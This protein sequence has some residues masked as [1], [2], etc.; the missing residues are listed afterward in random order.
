M[1]LKLLLVGKHTS[2]ELVVLRSL[3]CLPVRVVFVSTDCPNQFPSYPC[4]VRSEFISD[5][6]LLS[7]AGKERLLQIAKEESVAAV[8]V[9]WRE[10][11]TYW[12]Q[13][14]KNAFVVLSSPANTL[15]ELASKK[16]QLYYAARCGFGVLPTYFVSKQKVPDIPAVAFPIVLRPDGDTGQGVT[17]LFK[18]KVIMSQGE[19]D[20]AMKA[21][22]AHEKELIAQPFSRLSHLVLHGWRRTDGHLVLHAFVASRKFAGLVLCLERLADDTNE[23]LPARRFLEEVGV[24]GAFHFDLLWDVSTATPYFLEINARLGGTT[25]KV[26]ALGYNEPAAL[27]ASFYPAFADQATMRPTTVKVVATKTTILRY[28]LAALK[29]KTDLCDYPAEPHYKRVLWGMSA[30]F[31]TKD[32]AWSGTDWRGWFALK[33]ARRLTKKSK[34]Q[35]PQ[36]HLQHSNREQ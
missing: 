30:L 22:Q 16:R 3:S 21:I 13:E 19:L 35:Q 6:E 20:A 29:N 11:L 14:K 32:E 12:L 27:L 17:P 7:A 34:C 24:V 33:R 10:A 5:T 36:G 26:I 18:Y 1:P 2:V 9:F 23:F 4:L 15:W 31:R 8:Y 25:P 28:I